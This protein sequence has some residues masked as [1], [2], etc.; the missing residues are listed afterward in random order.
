MSIGKV[1]ALKRFFDVPEK[2]IT[3]NELIAFRREDPKGFD[4]L[5]TLAAAAL[6]ETLLVGKA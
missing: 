5:A 3:N 1:Q 6:G 2:P 4:E